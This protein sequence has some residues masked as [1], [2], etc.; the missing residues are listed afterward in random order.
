MKSVQHTSIQPAAT[1]P[2]PLGRIAPGGDRRFGA[3]RAALVVTTSLIAVSSLAYG[4]LVGGGGVHDWTGLISTDWHT[5]GNWSTNQIPGNDSSAIVIGGPG[6]VLL[7]ADSASLKSLL[8]GGARSVSTNGHLLRV[9]SSTATTTVTGFD[10][11]LFVASNGGAV[12]F[13]TEALTVTTDAR[14]IMSG[15]EVQIGDQLTLDN[16]GRIVGNGIIEVHSNSPAAFN[17]LDG[18]TLN[19][20]GGDLSIGVFGGGSLVMPEQIDVLQ[21]NRTLSL[22][23]PFFLPIQNVNLGAGCALDIANDW[24]LAG[25][26]SA[27]PGA[28]GVCRIEGAGDLTLAG[29]VGVGSSG[30]LQVDSNVA[31]GAAGEVVVDPNAVLEFNGL[32]DAALGHETSVGLNGV[33]RFNSSQ[34]PFDQWAGDI[35]LSAGVLEVNAPS[36]FWSLNGDLHL[37]SLF[38]LRARIDGSASLRITGTVSAPGLGGIVDGSMELLSGA[39][40]NLAQPNTRLVV[41]GVLALGNST[42]SGDGRI[43]VSP[44]GE[45]RISPSADVNVDILNQGEV[46]LGLTSGSVG[47]LYVGGEYTQEPSGRLRVEIGGAADAQRDVYETSGEADLAGELVVDLVNGYMPLVG[48]SFEVFWANGGITGAFES[49]SGASGFVVSYSANSVT[50]TYVGALFGDLNGDGIVDGAD[51]GILLAS[52]G[53]CDGC[54]GCI[55]DLDGD[56]MVDGADLGLLLANWS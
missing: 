17:G 47:Y 18:G 36:G 9:D 33:V 12:A 50:L 34:I 45:L 24:T 37:G 29:E 54:A 41:N 14:L 53:A 39:E 49:L 52:W 38:A 55:A 31:C 42:T 21:A 2:T 22:T 16:G 13:E 15:G 1:T 6:N 51:L 48:E 5:A 35:S 46:Q 28:S 8:I 25:S 20:S 10:S 3:A 32:A 4:G 7:G 30:T 56:C 44:T 40:M 11:S 19:V 26:L 23:G 43:E 27:S